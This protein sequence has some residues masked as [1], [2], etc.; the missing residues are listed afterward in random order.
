MPRRANL[1]ITIKEVAKTDPQLKIINTEEDHWTKINNPHPRQIVQRDDQEGIQVI[2][3]TCEFSIYKIKMSR[4]LFLV[5]FRAKVSKKH[6][7]MKLRFRNMNLING[8][9][10]SGILE[11]V[12]P[13]M[14]GIAYAHAARRQLKL[15]KPWFL[16]LT[17]KCRR[18]H[19]PCVLMKQAFTTEFRSASS[20]TP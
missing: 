18:T 15:Q 11:P 20:T 10:I 16:L 2:N 14:F 12:V 8:D 17:Y 3:N 19:W 4:Q 9:L 7:R 5:S 6:Q 1:I 13:S